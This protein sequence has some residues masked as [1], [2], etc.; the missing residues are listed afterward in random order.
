RPAAI[1]R[2][3][4]L[5][6]FVAVRPEPTGVVHHAGLRL[7]RRGAGADESVLVREP[8]GCRFHAWPRSACR[9]GRTPRSS[10]WVRFWRAACFGE[11]SRVL[12]CVSSAHAA[13]LELAL[14]RDVGVALAVR[15]VAGPRG[16]AARRAGPGELERV[17]REHS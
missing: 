2:A 15:K 10:R 12:E 11:A 7:L 17:P 9:P 4:E 3:V 13:A 1:D 14:L 8:A 16:V 6:A 5:G